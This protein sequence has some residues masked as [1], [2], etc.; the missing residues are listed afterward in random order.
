MSFAAESMPPLHPEHHPTRRDY[1]HFTLSSAVFHRC[2]DRVPWFGTDQSEQMSDYA[3]RT[4]ANSM[5]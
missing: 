2:D 3:P 4:L 5:M 1:A